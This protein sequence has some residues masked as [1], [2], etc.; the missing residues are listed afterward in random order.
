MYHI[1]YNKNGMKQRKVD[2]LLKGTPQGSLEVYSIYTV[3]KHRPLK[4]ILD[5]FVSALP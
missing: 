4:T 3:V 5:T 1:G 2:V